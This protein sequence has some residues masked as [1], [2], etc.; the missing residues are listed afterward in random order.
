MHPIK[1]RAVIEGVSVV[2][3]VLAV[4]ELSDGVQVCSAMCIM[5]CGDMSLLS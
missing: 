3:I 4:M 5:T 2:V 1:F